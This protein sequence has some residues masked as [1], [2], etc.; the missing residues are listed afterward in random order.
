MQAEDR[1][2]ET[3]TTEGAGALT[4]LGSPVGYLPFSPEFALDT[5]FE[6]L[7]EIEDSSEWEIGV[8][9]LSDATTLVRDSV[10]R[11]TNADTFV[12]F[13]A[14]LKTVSNILT[15]ATIAALGTTGSS[16]PPSFNGEDGEDGM[17]IVG[18]RGADGAAGAT[19][20]TGSQGEQGAVGFS[21]LDG[22][23]GQDGFSIVGQTGA[24]GA[25]G[26]TGSQGIQGAIGFAGLDGEDGQDGFSI[27]GAAGA[28]GATG[29]QGVQGIQGI[30]GVQGFAGDDGEDGM[31]IV[32]QRGADGADGS[33]GIQGLQGLWGMQGED[34][35]D[36][37]TIVGPQG[38]SGVGGGISEITASLTWD[39]GTN[40]ADTV[41]QTIAS[42]VLTATNFKGLT[43]I[44]TETTETSLDDFKLNG[45]T[46]NIENI[47]DG[48]SF[49]IRANASNEA[50]GVYTG[51]YKVIYA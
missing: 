48:V 7:I 25:T 29:E 31:T 11:S 42:G 43:L 13:S 50:S 5:S 28:T 39:F 44:P 30:A 21:G 6:Y 41:V 23:D 49:D 22:E 14:G 33:Q 35:E 27:V 2:V 24:T 8:G 47:I 17:S 51:T 9:H 10:E 1:V 32:G 19:G 26:E 38:A 34:G 20:A 4:L 40:E 18:Q 46:F 16:M 45:V 36:G 37:M 12:V 15:A 3:S